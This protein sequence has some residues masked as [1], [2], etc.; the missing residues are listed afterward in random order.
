MKESTNVELEG[1]AGEVG[2]VLGDDHLGIGD[3]EHVAVIGG[4]AAAL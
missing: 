4:R 1:G 2:G 3:C